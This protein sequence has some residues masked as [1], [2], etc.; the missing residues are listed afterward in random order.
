MS[1]LWLLFEQA[2]LW[3]SHFFLD[4][5]LLTCFGREDKYASMFR[6]SVKPRLSCSHEKHSSMLSAG[7][8]QHWDPDPT[9]EKLS[10]SSRGGYVSTLLES[11]IRKM[12][13]SGKV[14]LEFRGGLALSFAIDMETSS[15]HERLGFE[16][17]KI[18]GKP[19]SEAISKVWR[20]LRSEESA[21][22]WL[23]LSRAW[24]VRRSAVE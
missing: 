14:F 21:Q 6:L 2:S 23:C 20:N 11:V 8:T 17:R 16:H 18:K 7:E 22:A 4:F 15:H 10:P 19:I 24:S 1:H 3:E 5:L 13:S 12:G 9:L